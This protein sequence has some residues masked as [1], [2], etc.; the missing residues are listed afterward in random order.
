MSLCTGSWDSLVSMNFPRPRKSVVANQ[1]A[2]S[3]SKSGPCKCRV[4]EYQ[5]QHFDNLLA[6]LDF[7]CS[8]QNSIPLLACHIPNYNFLIINAQRRFSNKDITKDSLSMFSEAGVRSTE[9]TASSGF[10]SL[11]WLRIFASVHINSFF[12]DIFVRM[13]GSYYC[14]SV[15]YLSTTTTAAYLS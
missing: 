7:C 2:P 5:Q 1:I 11:N 4:Y 13:G 15:C 10:P 9:S 14:L 8:R 12:P 6:S 3:S